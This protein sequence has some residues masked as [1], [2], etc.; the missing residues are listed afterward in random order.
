MSVAIE[1]ERR[2]VGKIA[3]ERLARTVLPDDEDRHRRLL[4][5]GAAESDVEIAV[6]VVRGAVDMVHA[7]H[8]R[9]PD[10]DERG[11]PRQLL[12]PDRGG[13]PLQLFWE[14]HGQR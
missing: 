3:D 10:L 5:A 7:G 9:R 2:R 6:P 4:A 12:Y 1:R 8:E 11:F 13:S 14:L